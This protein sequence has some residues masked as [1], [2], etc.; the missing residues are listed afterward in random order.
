MDSRAWF[1]WKID[2]SES[3][4]L[5]F[6]SALST[7]DLPMHILN[8]SRFPIFR[9]FLSRLNIQVLVF[10]TQWN[11]KIEIHQCVKIERFICTWNINR[12]A[13]KI[14]QWNETI[15]DNFGKTP[16]HRRTTNEPQYQFQL[17]VFQAQHLMKNT[18]FWFEYY[19]FILGCSS[20]KL[21]WN[22]TALLTERLV[23]IHSEIS[24]DSNKS[25]HRIECM[26]II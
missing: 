11:R 8:K 22:W 25:M 13:A 21:Q 18:I 9:F 5:Q 19:N 15:R 26:R 24:I 1:T 4:D 20:S 6:S 23:F 16:T 12:V 2:N 14:K 10:L 7:V 3:I 17:T